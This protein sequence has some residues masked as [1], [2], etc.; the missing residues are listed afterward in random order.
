VHQDAHD[1]VEEYDEDD[2][3]MMSM[4]ALMN[5]STPPGPPLPLP[6]TAAAPVPPSMN[7]QATQPIA[8]DFNSMAGA[9]IEQWS[10]EQVAQW[11]HGKGLGEYAELFIEHAVDGET[12][13]E[14]TRE[15]LQEMGITKI[16]HVRSFLRQIA[17]LVDGKPQASPTN[18][19]SY[20]PSPVPAPQPE[21]QPHVL[22]ISIE[23]NIAAG[24]STLL[25]TLKSHPEFVLVPEPVSRWQN[26]VHDSERTN[27]QVAGGNLLGSF[28]G[29]PSRWA[30]TFQTYAFIS[31]M[32]AQSRPVSYF[33][34][35][36]SM[37]RIGAMSQDDDD[38]KTDPVLAEPGRAVKFIER[39]VYSD[40]FCF[41]ENCYEMGSFS[42]TEWGA[43]CDMHSWLHDK[44]SERDMTLD[45]IVYL[46]TTP[47]TCMKRLKQRGRSEES[48]VTVEY[49]TSIHDKHENW[50]MGHLHGDPMAKR[51]EQMP[52][53]VIDN[54]PDASE[55][56][57][58][59]IDAKIATF[60]ERL[61]QRQQ[62]QEQEQQ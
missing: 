19:T 18:T 52:I 39:S 54:E 15:D 28:Y 16:G 31:R 56:R 1:L 13:R 44:L 57:I 40:R 48:S 10:P 45:G 33:T 27:S 55:E 2:H 46:R 58:K 7:R 6:P 29:D 17:R 20:A 4:K 14:L 51:V 53:L 42:E 47:Q 24:K 62:Q 38:R 49:L 60:V 26:V 3:D 12:M 25:D 43:Y 21:K 35:S 34:K 37:R 50:L 9:P 30:F 61:R 41:A 59:E 36:S 11:V 5:K 23:G 8:I 22:Q 32:R